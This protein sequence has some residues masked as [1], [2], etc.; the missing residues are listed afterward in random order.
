[1]RA[2]GPLHPDRDDGSSLDGT[3]ELSEVPVFDLVFH[4]KAGGRNSPRSINADYHEALEVLL[5]RLG[6]LRAT[7][8]GISVDSSI[9]QELDSADRELSLEFPIVLS[10][11]T[12]AH[13][14][15]LQITR[16]QKTVARRPSAK[17]GG[18]NDQKRIRITLTFDGTAA[19]FDDL[20]RTLTS[21]R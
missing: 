21:G 13:D 9:A 20:A 2:T 15:R 18:G 17:P 19:S 10:P 7:I 5:S 8:L 6:S 3:F 11:A 1:M 14:L 12:D 16:A 4:H